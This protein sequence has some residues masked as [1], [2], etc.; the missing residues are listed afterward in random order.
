MDHAKGWD[1]QF[2]IGPLRN[3]STRMFRAFGP[4]AGA[5]SMSDA[6]YIGPWAK[7][8]DR[9]DTDQRF[10]KTILYNLNPK[11]NCAFGTMTRNFQ[12]GSIA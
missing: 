5:D 12:D 9:L 2:H 3:N 10:A 1:Q 6:S 4:D 11:D 8:I 7:F